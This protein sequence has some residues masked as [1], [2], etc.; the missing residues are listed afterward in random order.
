MYNLLVPLAT[1]LSHAR[2]MFNY[3]TFVLMSF[4]NI[5]HGNSPNI[6]L[7]KRGKYEYFSCHGRR[8]RTPKTF[9]IQI[10]MGGSAVS[11]FSRP[12]NVLVDFRPLQYTFQRIRAPDARG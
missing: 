9:R 10:R 6:N 12:K 5:P 7:K 8:A 1:R 3:L 2:V 11:V 4:E